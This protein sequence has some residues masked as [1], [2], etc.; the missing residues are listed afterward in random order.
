MS[1]NWPAFLVGCAALFVV[2]AP[3]MVATAPLSTSA[4]TSPIQGEPPNAVVY[5]AVA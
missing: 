1:R 5:Q 4:R 3:R 2:A